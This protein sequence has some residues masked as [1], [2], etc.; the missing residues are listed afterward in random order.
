M[1]YCNLFLSEYKFQLR[2]SNS[3]TQLSKI[4]QGC[5]HIKWKAGFNAVS[6]AGEKMCDQIKMS[7]NYQVFLIFCGKFAHLI[8][9][10]GLFICNDVEWFYFGKTV[11]LNH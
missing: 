8:I 1:H 3:N 9:Q 4:N 2:Y 6:P 7:L 5:I 10:N 11:E